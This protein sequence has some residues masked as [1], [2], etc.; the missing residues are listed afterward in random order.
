MQDLTS[1]SARDLLL[2]LPPLAQTDAYTLP[3]FIQTRSQAGDYG[4]PAISKR[5]NLAQT[6]PKQTTKLLPVTRPCA[7]LQ[8][9]ATTSAPAAD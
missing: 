1:C 3:R 4:R 7:R 2:V 8:L 5:N 9:P 6:Q